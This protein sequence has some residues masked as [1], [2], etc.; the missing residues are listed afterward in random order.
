[1]K[2]S[3][4]SILALGVL[5]SFSWSANA[6]NVQSQKAISPIVL[7][8]SNGEFTPPVESKDDEI[9]ELAKTMYP[10]NPTYETVQGGGTVRTYQMP[11]WATNAQMA[12]KTNGRPLR[13][14]AQLWIGPIRTTHTMAINCMD[15]TK[16]PYMSTISF[17]KLAPVI[18]V[19]TSDSLEYPV[20]AS[21]WVPPPERGDRIKQTIEEIWEEATAEEKKLIQGADVSGGN[22][23]VRT[24][25]IPADVKSV[26]L[27]AW[28]KDT[29][30]KSLKAKIEVLQGPNNKMQDYDLQCGG[31]TQ[32]F[33]AVLQTPGPGW[34]VRVYNKKFVEDGLFELVVR[35]F[36]YV[37]E[38]NPVTAPVVETKAVEAQPPQQQQAPVVKTRPVE[39][40]SKPKVTFSTMHSQKQWWQ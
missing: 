19:L 31:S 22:G 21:V 36:E 9:A 32:P 8:S 18:R 3:S 35:P 7:R 13:A 29:S 23:A 14:T 25:E 24:W 11:E 16:T 20:E 6:F 1:M 5:Q 27:V 34:I 2:V 33:H 15:G 26:Q 38:R 30:K 10:I 39:P 17:K 37:E 40:T 28:S 12:F 4:G